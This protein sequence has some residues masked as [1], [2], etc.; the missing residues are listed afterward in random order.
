MSICPHAYVKCRAEHA[1]RF[2]PF[3]IHA[4]SFPYFSHLPNGCDTN[5]YQRDVL[6]ALDDERKCEEKISFKCDR[7]T[8]TWLTNEF[9]FKQ[10]PL[11][12]LNAFTHQPKNVS[13]TLQK[14]CVYVC[15]RVWK[16]EGWERYQ[17]NQTPACNTH[18]C[19]H[20]SHLWNTKH[21]IKSDTPDIRM[22]HA[23]WLQLAKH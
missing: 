3:L 20:K 13:F 10:W 5:T 18:K 9:P 1:K 8:V 15:V 22:T 21:I 23:I 7:S 16:T 14:Y 12:I 4:I 11:N 2:K 19:A 17:R 6:K